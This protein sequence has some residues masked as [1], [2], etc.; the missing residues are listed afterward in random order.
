MWYEHAL[1]DPSICIYILEERDRGPVAQARYS[2]RS[3]AVAEVHVTVAPS[4]R[5][6][7]VGVRVLR[8]SAP[9]ALSSLGVSSITA[10]VIKGNAPSL[11]AFQ[12]GGYQI[13]GE[14]TVDGRDCYGLTLTA[15]MAWERR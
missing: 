8:E 13:A 3:D 5:G 1:S 11:G 2:R 10:L 9:L 6:R 14:K 7:G 12:R 4:S 15:E